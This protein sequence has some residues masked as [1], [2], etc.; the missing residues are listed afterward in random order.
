MVNFAI[1]ERL[2]MALVLIVIIQPQQHKHYL[3]KN[4]SVLSLKSQAKNVQNSNSH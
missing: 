3:I 4:D 1:F 2:F